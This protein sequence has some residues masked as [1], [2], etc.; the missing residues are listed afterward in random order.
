[1]YKR[2]LVA[3][4]LVW[5]LL[6]QTAISWAD[7]TIYIMPDRNDLPMKDAIKM[8]R[9]TLCN[10]FEALRSILDSS[11]AE[12]TFGYLD[13]NNPHE[14]IWVIAFNNPDAYDGTYYVTISRSGQLISYQ[15]P[16][17]MEYGPD[18]NELTGTTTATPGQNDVTEQQAIEIARDGLKEIGDFETRMDQL[19]T[20][21]I[22]VYGNRYNNGNEPVWIIYFY[23]GDKLQQKVLLGYDG[24]YICSVPA[25]KQFD[26]TSKP[27]EGL[28]T[29][30][31]ELNFCQMTLQ[32]KA[33]FTKT[34]QPKVAEYLKNHPYFAN[35]DDLFYLATRHTYG[36]PK[37]DELSQEK[38]TTI[39]RHA[40]IAKGANQDTIDKRPIAY[41]YD[42]TNAEQPLWKLLIYPDELAA[43]E[44]FLRDDN[45]LSYQVVLNA[46]DG[47]IISIHDNT[48]S[49]NFDGWNF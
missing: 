40:I 18:D 11:S 14:P 24:T 35:S 44:D 47:T 23:Q 22:F 31:A 45:R 46:R 13:G 4:L 1:M 30:F 28:G 41:T 15:A 7:Q 33:D 42:V 3:F 16:Y 39:A 25:G 27:D 32:Q 26:R 8:A 12:A 49:Q 36:L 29:S 17:V 2:G 10:H 37:G 9:T 34:W 20:K 43:K 38:A 19:S 48:D 6:S 5:M 21:A